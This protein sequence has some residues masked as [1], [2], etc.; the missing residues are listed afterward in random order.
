MDNIEKKISRTRI[1]SGILTG[2]GT[3]VAIISII[4][5]VIN[6]NQQEKELQKK[7][8]ILND[9]IT[10]QKLLVLQQKQQQQT[11]I[12]TIQQY[13]IVSHDQN[14][15]R[16]DTFFYFPVEK[17]YTCVNVSKEKLNERTKFWWYHH[18][19]QVF[20]LTSENTDIKKEKSDFIVAIKQ[21][22]TSQITIFLNIKLNKNLKIFYVDNSILAKYYKK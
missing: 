2:I 10:K 22:E 3:L 11:I 15:E 13:L 16:L 5:L 9:S 19:E 18:S 1:I 6:S 4:Y 17:Y 8:Q 14:Y 12:N 21:S 7:N 20:H